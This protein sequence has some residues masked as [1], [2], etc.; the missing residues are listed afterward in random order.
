ML[1]A[2]AQH[3][4]LFCELRFEKERVFLKPFLPALH[5]LVLGYYHEVCCGTAQYASLFLLKRLL[6]IIKKTEVTMF[7]KHFAALY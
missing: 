1:R 2:V 4:L 5:G 7:F 3:T 6:F